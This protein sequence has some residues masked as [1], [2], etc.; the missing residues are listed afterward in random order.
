MNSAN[1]VLYQGMLDAA[2]TEL[3]KAGITEDGIAQRIATRFC[4]AHGGNTYRVPE[5]ASVRREARDDALCEDAS[6]MTR[7]QLAHKYHLNVSTVHEILTK[8]KIK[9]K[10]RTKKR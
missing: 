1:P 5:L 6:K 10:K 8:R 9:A 7:R 3:E 2:E 4:D